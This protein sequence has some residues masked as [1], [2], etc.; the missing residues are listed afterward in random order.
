MHVF[1]TLPATNIKYYGLV[2]FSFSLSIKLGLNSIKILKLLMKLQ[3]ENE[4][5]M[6]MKSQSHEDPM[7]QQS[8]RCL[9]LEG[10]LDTTCMHIKQKA[11]HCLHWHDL[12]KEPGVT[13]RTCLK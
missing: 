7:F 13:E 12:S 4:V 1:S 6:I 2:R 8:Q 11:L 10:D 5:T 9:G 3:T